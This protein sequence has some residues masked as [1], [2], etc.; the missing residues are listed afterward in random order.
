MDLNLL[1]R[2]TEILK[3]IATEDKEYYYLREDLFT[4][5]DN[6]TQNISVLLESTAQQQL[7]DGRK[8][9][10]DFYEA[11]L[12]TTD[13]IGSPLLSEVREMLKGKVF[14]DKD[15]CYLQNISANKTLFEV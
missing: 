5:E 1:E 11:V 14:F 9:I 6:F 4:T 10:Q 7:K 3:P 8:T 2:F 12:D 15:Y 13:K